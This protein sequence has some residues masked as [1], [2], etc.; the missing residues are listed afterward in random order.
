V[1][2]SIVTPGCRLIWQLTS[3]TTQDPQDLSSRCGRKLFRS[4]QSDRILSTIS[5]GN[6][7]STDPANVE[8]LMPSGS[9]DFDFK[10]A[11][12]AKTVALLSVVLKRSTL[13]RSHHPDGESDG[14]VD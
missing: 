5:T 8:M 14:F 3:S 10:G 9:M 1:K 11:A 4:V 12:F 7:P 13:D 2:A 6:Q